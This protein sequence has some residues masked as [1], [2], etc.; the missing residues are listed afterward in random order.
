MSP[1]AALFFATASFAG[2]IFLGYLFSYSSE[3]AIAS[4][5]LFLFQALIIVFEKIKKRSPSRIAIATCVIS[6]FLLSGVL[7]AQLSSETHPVV[8]ESP[9]TIEGEIIREPEDRDSYQRF[10]LRANGKESF[11][12]VY[13]P[14]Y[15]SF[16]VGSTISIEGE[17][18]EPK[19]LFP[20]GDKKGFDYAAYLANKGVGSQAFFP[21]IKI[22]S[23]EPTSFVLQLRRMKE[24]LEKHL[25]A[26]ISYPES[27]LASGMIFGSSDM[28]KNMNEEFRVAGV[29][30]IVVLSGF[31]IAIIVS[32]ALILL[33]S[34][35]LFLRTLLASLLVIAFVAMVGAEASIV[36]ATIMAGI[37]LLA[38]VSGREYVAKQALLLS[39]LI[40]VLIDPYAL[41]HDISLHLSFI[42]TAGIVYG[43]TIV[44]QARIVSSLPRYLKDML[45]T[46]VAAYVA[47][48]PYQM[49]AFGSVSA[50]ALFANV[51]IVPLVPIAMALS[52]ATAIV[53]YASSW[54]SILFGWMTTLLLQAM[55]GFIGFISLL[56]GASFN[57][58]LSL[59]GMVILYVILVTLI[60][61]FDSLEN[62]TSLSKDGV[63]RDATIYK[64]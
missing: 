29:S 16:L 39:F 41:L 25:H 7:R 24:S 54:L 60:L 62:E 59:G 45:S 17:I 12:E 13:A 58:S 23:E 44:S 40:I 18:T 51:L 11:I 28:P 1:Y 35:P 42:A 34:I 55:N 19:P 2:G 8:C 3:L 57:L 47:T 50:Y 33:A 26:Y 63:T 4:L 9:C 46:T 61:Y 52:F 64:Y 31:N 14:L 21:K 38:I 6:L 37:S 10:I 32:F 56:P 27:T 22:I 36:R 5:F 43:S 48:L 49:Y 20:H 53:S 15:P 30:H